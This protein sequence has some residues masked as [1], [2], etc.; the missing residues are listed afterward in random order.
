MQHISMS[1]HQGSMGDSSE[2]VDLSLHKITLRLRLNVKIPFDR[3]YP[4]KIEIS[5][6]VFKYVL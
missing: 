1:E 2:A 5:L 3:N 4:S 6:C